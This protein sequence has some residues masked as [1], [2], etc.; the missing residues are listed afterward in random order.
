MARKGAGTWVAENCEGEE[1][2]GVAVDRQ[3]NGD[4]RKEGNASRH[5]RNCNSF[6]RGVNAGVVRENTPARIERTRRSDD[7]P[8]SWWSCGSTGR[9]SFRFC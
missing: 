6:A 7:V 2:E 5:T 4:A 8:L 1:M 9:E 3:R